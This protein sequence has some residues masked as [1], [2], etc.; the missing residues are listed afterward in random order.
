MHLFWVREVTGSIPGS[1]K[2]FCLIYVLL[3]LLLC[4]YFFV[5]KHII[6]HKIW[7]NIFAM[8]IYVEFLT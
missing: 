7:Q 8:L 6:C 4:Y 2:G 1:G 5:Q 3:L